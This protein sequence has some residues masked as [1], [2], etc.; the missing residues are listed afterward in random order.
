[1][2]P[3]Q[4]D[5]V[6]RHSVCEP[7][8]VRGLFVELRRLR[9]RLVQLLRILAEFGYLYTRVGVDLPI[10]GYLQYRVAMQRRRQD[11]R[12]RAERGA[13][14]DSNGRGYGGTRLACRA[15]RLTKAR[16]QSFFESMRRAAGKARQ[17]HKVVFVALPLRNVLM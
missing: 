2:L 10:S 3:A 5:R 6:E 1:M 15:R 17:S 4:L 16:F 12:R 9:R 7:G 13:R 8:A 11:Q 14:L